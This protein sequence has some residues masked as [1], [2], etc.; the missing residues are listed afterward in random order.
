MQHKE[1]I[2][3]RSTI[4]LTKANCKQHNELSTNVDCCSVFFKDDEALNDQ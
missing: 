2:F 4:V 1:L 3:Q